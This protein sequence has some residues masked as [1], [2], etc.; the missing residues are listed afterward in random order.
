MEVL[1]AS[2][3]PLDR[4]L[5][6]IKEFNIQ[7]NWDEVVMPNGEL[8]KCVDVSRISHCNSDEAT[9]TSTRLICLFET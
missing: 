3:I 1:K 5:S 9:T 6:M 7:P 2:E 4:F 8:F